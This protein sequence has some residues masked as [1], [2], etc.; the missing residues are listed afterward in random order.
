MICAPTMKHALCLFLSIL[1]TLTGAPAIA[2]ADHVVRGA[3]SVET[4][5]HDTSKVQVYVTNDGKHYHTGTCRVF[6]AGWMESGDSIAITPIPD[7]MAASLLVQV[8][9]SR[10][11]FG[12]RDPES[13]YGSNFQVPASA[14]HARS[15]MTLA[16][17]RGKGYLPCRGCEAPK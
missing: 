2:Q 4:A 13:Y 12:G 1:G 11:A 16:A 5:D 15:A 17:A 3:G 7:M 10:K 8:V 9:A 14:A 6:D